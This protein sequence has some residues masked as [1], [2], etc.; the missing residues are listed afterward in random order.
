[1]NLPL[2]E[3]AAPHWRAAAQGE[4]RV[5]HCTACDHVWY[6]PARHCPRCLSSEIDWKTISGRGLVLGHA[7]FH[8]SYFPDSPL[9]LPYTVI[10]VRLDEGPQLYSNPVDPQSIFAVGEVVTAV[11]VPLTDEQGLVRFEAV[12]SAA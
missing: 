10:H 5:P 6:P 8:R 1:M 11:F 4:L 3:L 9:P 12:R 7:V 2:P